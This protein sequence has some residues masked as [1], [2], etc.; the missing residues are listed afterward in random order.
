MGHFSSPILSRTAPAD[1]TIADCVDGRFSVTVW[2]EARC[3]GRLVDLARLER[4][5]GRKLLDLMR[6]GAF[7]CVRCG[8]I[9]TAV[10]VSTTEM[11]D[12]VL[13]WSV[14]DD[15]MPAR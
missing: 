2:C 3:G 6:E 10:T 13:R 4:L 1:L 7:S 15:A 14:G 9:A 8:G 11:A 5:A 12:R